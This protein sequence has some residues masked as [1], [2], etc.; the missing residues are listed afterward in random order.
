MVLKIVSAV[1]NKRNPLRYRIILLLVSGLLILTLATEVGGIIFLL[2]ARSVMG[3]TADGASLAPSDLV[4]PAYTILTAALGGL[5]ILRSSSQRFGWLMLALGTSLAVIGLA[6]EYSVLA[7]VAAPGADYSLAPL[8]AWVQDLWPIP[9]MLLLSLPFLFPNGRLP[10]P[11]WR[12][13][14]WPLMAAWGFLRS[15]LL[16]LGDPYRTLSWCTNSRQ[17]T[18]TD[19]FH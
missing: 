10:S 5:I 1:L 7:F 18:P 17:A 11:R 15:F 13:I 16:S 19:S 9:A 14:F 6:M 2:L 12:A 8:A 4:E 3:L